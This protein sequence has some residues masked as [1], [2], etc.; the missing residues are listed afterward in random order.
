MIRYDLI[1]DQG[2]EFDG[3][4]RDSAAYDGQARRGLV[5]CLVCNSIKVE[6]Q[7][8]APGIPAKSNKKVDRP[9]KMMA[10]PVDPRSAML[11]GMMREV[12]KSVEANAEYVGGKFAEEAR[13][14]HYAETAKRGIYGEATTDDAKA[15]IDEGIDVHPLPRLPEDSN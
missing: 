7:L 14:I 10:G 2:H 5:A 11:L 12:R 8:M 9:Q 4:F 1:C 6:K 3:W 15:L 13:R